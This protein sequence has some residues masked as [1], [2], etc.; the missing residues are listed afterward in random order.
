[1]CTDCGNRHIIET[2]HELICNMCGLVLQER[3]FTEDPEW[4]SFS[5]DLPMYGNHKSN[6]CRV[7]PSHEII[8]Q[9]TRDIMCCI[10]DRTQLPEAICKSG[11]LLYEE[12]RKHCSMNKKW[13]VVGAFVFYAQRDLQSGART[14]EEL[15]EALGLDVSTFSKALT[16]VKDVLYQSKS[17]QRLVAPRDNYRD[18][19]HRLVASIQSIPEKRFLEVKRTVYKLHSKIQ[20]PDSVFASI[21]ADKLN[22]G[23]VY[24]AC[25]FLHIKVTMKEISDFTCTSMATIIK[26]ESLVKGVLS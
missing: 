23:L 1:M 13:Y 10:Q 7:E 21:Q 18:T 12:F 26:I 16:M 8:K 6:M 2:S 20:K 5:D 3:M 11:G 25:R 14:K 19:L 17:T 22:A 15:C 9:E 4:R 24:M